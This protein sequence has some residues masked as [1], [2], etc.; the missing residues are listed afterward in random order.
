MAAASEVAAA[1]GLRAVPQRR[2][3]R[4][5]CPSC[6]Y[7]G[8]LAVKD[9]DGRALWWCACCQDGAGVTA[10]V[11]RALGGGWGGTAPRVRM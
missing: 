9:K 10:A 7:A 3:W 4:G 11:W 6:G 1:L 2:E 5:D 8:G